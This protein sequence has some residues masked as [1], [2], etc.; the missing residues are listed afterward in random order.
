MYAKRGSVLLLALLLL[1]GV[2]A[3]SLSVSRNAIDEL[4]AARNL[5]T[6]TSATYLAETGLEQG[7]YF[8]R[9][10]TMPLVNFPATGTLNAGTQLGTWA[11]TVSVD[12]VSSLPPRDLTQNSTW[13]LDLYDPDDVSFTQTFARSV[14]LS[15]TG[16]GWLEVSWAGWHDGTWTPATVKQIS[17]AQ[18]NMIV[19]FSSPDNEQ[20]TLFRVRFKAL[21]GNITGLIVSGIGGNLPTDVTIKATGTV[22]QT[23]QAV[24][25][26]LPRQS[27]LSGLYDFVI[28]SQ[29]SLIKD[30]QP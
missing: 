11:R 29:D 5:S 27:P 8:L 6:A 20:A 21:R 17:P 14:Q 19:N 25:A 24:Q 7:L 3:A 23:R 22:G 13:Q 2:S 10:T 28:F 16:T 4:V 15:W 30:L 12:A 9:K 18:T 26:K 1:A